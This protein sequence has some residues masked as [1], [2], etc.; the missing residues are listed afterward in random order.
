MTAKP[1]VIAIDGP[2]GSGKSST[3]RG[4]AQRLGLEYLDTGAMYRAATIVYRELGLRPDQ[5]EE[6]AAAI[7][8]QDFHF[9]T[10]VSH[11]RITLSGRDITEEIRSPEVSATVS[12]VATMVPVRQL[13]QQRQR[14]L[15]ASAGTGIVIE[16]RDMTTVVAPDADLRILL[17]ADP[18]ARMQRREDQLHGALTKDQL[19]DQILRRDRDDSTVANFTKPA[20]GVTLIDSTYMNLEDVITTICGLV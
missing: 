3:A 2:S 7:R 8:D 10:D 19:E 17:V 5:P 4:A 20:D 13:L 15:I 12:Q 11:Q 14:E 6:T 18:V 9:P 1:L 16:G